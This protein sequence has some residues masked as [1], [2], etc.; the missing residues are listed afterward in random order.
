[1]PCLEGAFRSNLRPYDEAGSPLVVQL[2]CDGRIRD[3]CRIDRRS[4]GRKQA[5]AKSTKPGQMQQV[6]LN[7]VVNGIEAMT[8]STHSPRCYG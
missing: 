8:A 2:P 4:A 7:L 6:V 5:W 3:R 1:M